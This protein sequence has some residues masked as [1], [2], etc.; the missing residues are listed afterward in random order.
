MEIEMPVAMEIP[1]PDEFHQEYRH[2]ENN[3]DRRMQLGILR[4]CSVQDNQSDFLFPALSCRRRSVEK[5]LGPLPQAMPSATSREQLINASADDEEIENELLE[6]SA[7]SAEP[8][9]T[10]RATISAGTTSLNPY[11][12]KRV[13]SLRDWPLGEPEMRNGDEYFELDLKMGQFKSEEVS[14]RIVGKELIIHCKPNIAQRRQS[15]ESVP[16]EIFRCYP[17]PLAIPPSAADVSIVKDDEGCWLRVA[18]RKPS[19]IK[20]PIG[21]YTPEMPE[22]LEEE[23]IVVEL[24]QTEPEVRMD[25]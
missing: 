3:R 15:K 16:R 2:H 7:A 22:I 8:A 4:G 10:R 11:A 6:P 17:L 20:S 5:L 25:D 1:E 21:L 19:G 14:A 24:E 23:Q 12:K 9:P 13:H 18:V